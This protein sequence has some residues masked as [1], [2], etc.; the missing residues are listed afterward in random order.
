MGQ[1]TQQEY[2]ELLGRFK[3][4]M[5]GLDPSS[6]GRIRSFTIVPVT[7]A[8]AVARSFGRS[9]TSMSFLRALAQPVPQVWELQEQAEADAAKAEQAAADVAKATALEAAEKARAEAQRAVEEQAAA[10]ADKA[11]A[12]EAAT[13]AKTEAALAAKEQAEADAA[14]AAL[15]TQL[16]EE[17]VRLM[18]P[19]CLP[20]VVRAAEDQSGKV[21]AQV[22]E[23]GVEVLAIWQKVAAPP[24]FAAAYAACKEA[25]KV[26]RQERKRKQAVEAVA[27]PELAAAKRLA[28]N[29]GKQAQKKRKMAKVKRARDASGSLGL[30]KKSRMR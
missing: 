21:H 14:K 7:T 30:N 25:Q 16:D 5:E 12:Q 10:E 4:S 22:K 27:D 11:K 24:D 9:P 2:N 8:A 26:S 13:A 17:Q 19:V 29:A 18:L 3:L 23:L 20:V 6:V 28:K 15:A 1:V